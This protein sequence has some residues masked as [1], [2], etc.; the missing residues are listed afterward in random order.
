MTRSCVVPG[1]WHT[2]HTWISFVSFELELTG[3]DVRLGLTFGGLCKFDERRVRTSG[4][5]ED[6]DFWGVLMGDDT[7]EGGDVG[8]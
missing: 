7:I 5:A 2:K 3:V 4:S 6:F 1:T 8:A